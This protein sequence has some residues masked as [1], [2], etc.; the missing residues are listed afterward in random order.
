[1]ITCLY[2]VFN[3]NQDINSA[4]K[5]LRNFYEHLN[6]NGICIISLYN[7]KNPYKQVSFHFGE[8][9]DKKAAKINQFK[10]YP[11]EKKVRSDHL[12][13]IKD[14]EKVDFDVEANDTFRIFDF[15]E[16]HK[17]VDES[18][19][20]KYKLLDGFSFSKANKDTKY[21]LWILFKGTTN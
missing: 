15:D 20:E 11:D 10:Y 17:L 9:A 6:D 16:I 13:L 2:S 14:K 1:M 3:Y 8:E 7:E 18:E 21:P 19:F 5:T 4:G 12:V